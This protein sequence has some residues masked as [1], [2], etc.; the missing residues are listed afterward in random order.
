MQIAVRMEGGLG[1][2]ILSNRFVLAIK[3]KYP[4]AKIKCFC[5]NEG[6][7]HQANFLK[8]FFSHLYESI[9]VI[10]FRKSKT[11]TINTPFGNEVYPAYISNMPDEILA[12][13]ESADLF[14][15]LH[16][17][18]LKWLNYDFDWQRY[19][20]FFPKPQNVPNNLTLPKNFVLTHLY[21]RKDSPYN[22]GQ[23]NINSILTQ[24]AAKTSVVV[25]TT[26]ED[27]HVYQSFLD[28]PRFTFVTGGIEDCVEAAAKCSG[29]IGIDSGIRLLPV[30]FSKPFL[31]LS[32]DCHEPQ[33][34]TYSHEIRWL[35]FRKNVFPVNTDPSLVSEMILNM[36]NY[37]P[38]RI[39]PELD[40]AAVARLAVVDRFNN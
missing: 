21:A 33:R 28:D 7:D 15:D 1:D 18:G 5:D 11:F 12:K 20:Y 13:F 34:P 32:K 2:V 31:F 25:I 26:L 4:S 23:D 37:A 40:V 10:P 39:F 22:A 30:S 19:Y 29:F 6:H 9:E 35:I 36:I 3:E 38:S 8:K 24:L 16:I 27:R 17:D 14:Y